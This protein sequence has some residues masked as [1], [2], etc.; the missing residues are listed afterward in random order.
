MNNCEF[1]PIDLDKPRR[2][3]LPLGSL[4][5]A[6]RELNKI[7]AA[8]GL[9]AVSIFAAVDEQIKAAKTTGG[10][11]PNVLI[12]LLWA[13]LLRDDPELTL[14]QV[15]AIDANSMYVSRKVFACVSEWMQ[16]RSD[17][18]E[19]ADDGNPPLEHL[20]GSTSGPVAGSSSD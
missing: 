7:R 11:D 8:E 20:N 6:Q 16:T 12:V 5:Q 10:V 18:P 9:P 2:M 17:A 15:E 4:R 14:A 1:I 3:A 19:V 13:S